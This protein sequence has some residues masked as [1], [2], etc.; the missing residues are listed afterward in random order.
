MAPFGGGYWAGS[1]LGQAKRLAWASE[2][3]GA[4]HILPLLFEV[5]STPVWKLGTLLTGNWGRYAIKLDTEH[6]TD[7]KTLCRE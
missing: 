6:R 4:S 2:C 3:G 5:C 1:P 7:S